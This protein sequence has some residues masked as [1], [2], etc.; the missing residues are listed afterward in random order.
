M[1]APVNDSRRMNFEKCALTSGLLTPQQ[2]EEA[3]AAFA[4]AIPGSQRPAADSAEGEFSDK[5][6]ADK[7]VANGL[8]NPWQAKQLLDGRDKV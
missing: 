8:L 2:L 7:I 1:S 6:L 4:A 3:R 5:D